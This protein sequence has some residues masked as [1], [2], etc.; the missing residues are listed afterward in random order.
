MKPWGETPLVSTRGRLK[1][2]YKNFRKREPSTASN[3]TACILEW[4]FHVSMVSSRSTKKGPPLTLRFAQLPHCRKLCSAL[5]LTPSLL[6]TSVCHQNINTFL[7][8]RQAALVIVFCFPQVCARSVMQFSAGEKLESYLSLKLGELIARSR[9]PGHRP[10]PTEVKY[11]G[12]TT[13]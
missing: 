9:A 1:K 4:P 10:H 6:P 3:I 7:S 11:L 2:V 8:S 5:C 12:F 13:T